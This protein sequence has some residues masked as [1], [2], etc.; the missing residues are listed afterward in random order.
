VPGAVED[1]ER[2]KDGH[3]DG[4]ERLKSHLVAS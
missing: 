2:V 4:V 1:G 3:V